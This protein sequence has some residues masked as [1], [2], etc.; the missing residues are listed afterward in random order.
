LRSQAITQQQLQNYAHYQGNYERYRLAEDRPYDLEEQ[1]LFHT[2]FDWV[3][4]YQMVCVRLKNQPDA[5][6]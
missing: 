5:K 3:E 1:A 4:Q 6:H 2:I